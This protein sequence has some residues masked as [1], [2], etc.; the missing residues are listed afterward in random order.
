MGHRTRGRRIIKPPAV[1]GARIGFLTWIGGRRY[2][3]NIQI[4]SHQKNG[5]K[6]W[7]KTL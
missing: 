1:E 2:H 5:E 7:K 6:I 3:R 4:Y